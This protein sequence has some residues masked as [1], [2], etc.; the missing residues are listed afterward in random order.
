LLTLSKDT[1]KDKKLIRL[2][3]LNTEIGHPVIAYLII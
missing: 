1:S 2:G 3:S